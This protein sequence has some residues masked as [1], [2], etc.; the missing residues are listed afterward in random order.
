MVEKTAFEKEQLALAKANYR[1]LTKN[2]DSFNF[3]LNEILK[4]FSKS[5][6][7]DWGGFSFNKQKV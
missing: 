5:K 3:S 2:K 4:E 1:K 7:P 6:L